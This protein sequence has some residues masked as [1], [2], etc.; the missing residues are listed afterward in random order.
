[1]SDTASA[2]G[3]MKPSAGQWPHELT[4]QQGEATWTC[5][6]GPWALST[7]LRI[8]DIGVFCLSP[9]QPT[10]PAWRSVRHRPGQS[11]HRERP[12][13]GLWLPP[14]PL[15]QAQAQRVTQRSA[16]LLVHARVPVQQHSALWA[17][18]SAA[19]AQGSAPQLFIHLRQT[20]AAGLRFNH[21]S[22]NAT[23]ISPAMHPEPD[24][25]HGSEH[26]PVERASKDPHATQGMQF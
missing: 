19:L 10:M 25:L 2:G 26:M 4:H 22:S 18:Q 21:S 8:L 6:Q 5:L 1:M 20:D 14:G 17:S 9:G 12:Q 11:P 15:L 24:T 23:T 16:D 3:H 13:G 7:A